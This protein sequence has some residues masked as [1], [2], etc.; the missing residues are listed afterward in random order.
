MKRMNSKRQEGKNRFDECKISITK[1]EKF[2]I[3]K[4]RELVKRDHVFSILIIETIVC[5]YLRHVEVNLLN[6]FLRCEVC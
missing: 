6:I 5:L 1:G 2:K 4:N 3:K